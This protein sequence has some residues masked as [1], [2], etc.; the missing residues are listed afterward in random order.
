ARRS[1]RSGNL[2]SPAREAKASGFV[3][4]PDAAG[5]GRHVRNDGV[6]GSRE[7]RSKPFV[8]I[9]GQYVEHQGRHL[10]FGDRTD[11]DEID[12]HGC[13]RGP[14]FVSDH[15]QESARRGTQVQN[16][17]ASFQNAEATSD[18]FDL[19]SGARAQTDVLRPTKIVVLRVV[20]LAHRSPGHYHPAAPLG[21]FSTAGL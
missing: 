7:G 13:A 11:R 6:E 19:E 18:L 12:S 1:A 8:E 21:K 9:I 20:R 5:L 17:S 2:Q 10:R 14:D 16:A 4:R 15:L 3:S